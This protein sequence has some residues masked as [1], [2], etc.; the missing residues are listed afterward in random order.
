MSGVAVV[1]VAHDSGDLLVEC[2]ARVAAA[3]GVGEVVVV[4]NGSRDG[5]PARTGARVIRNEGN[6][7]FAVACNQGAAATR[8]PYLLFLNPDCLVEPDTV[9]RLL[10]VADP[11]LSSAV[12][13]AFGRTPQPLSHGSEL[14][15]V[16]ATSG[17]LM[18]VRRRVFDAIGGFDEGYRLHCEDLD[19]CR[20]IRAAGSR[21]VVAERVPVVHVK[22]TSSRARPW[23]VLWQKHRSMLRYYRKFDAPKHAWPTR[24]FVTLGWAGYTALAFARQAIKR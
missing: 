15:T 17:A 3:A 7:G 19:L 2:V 11:D 16:D 4:D 23:F 21:V 6:P 10:A 20:R 12:G 5:A 18:L 22:G 9:S 8:A 13:R 24:A 14:T 1:V